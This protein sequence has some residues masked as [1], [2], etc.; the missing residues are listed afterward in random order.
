M[1]KLIKFSDKVIEV[2]YN[3]KT[4]LITR[5]SYF[6]DYPYVV[7]IKAGFADEPLDMSFQSDKDLLRDVNFYTSSSKLEIK[8][9]RRPKF[10]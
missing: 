5:K 7:F 3:S 8:C 4:R 10:F 6:R 9:L 2:V 1:K